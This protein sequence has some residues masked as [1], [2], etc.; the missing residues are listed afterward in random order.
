MC[1]FIDYFY[2]LAIEV[3]FFALIIEI[4]VLKKCAELGTLH[5]NSTRLR[6]LN[7]SKITPKSVKK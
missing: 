2:I 1:R 4:S 5:P 6:R 3:L 7:F